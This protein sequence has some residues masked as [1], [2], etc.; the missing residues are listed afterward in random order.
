[1]SVLGKMELRAA[2]SVAANT[3]AAIGRSTAAPAKARLVRLKDPL[4]SAVIAA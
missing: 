1:M 2:G 4:L 3:K